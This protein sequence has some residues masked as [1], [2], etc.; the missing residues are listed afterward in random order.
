M[1]EFFQ[2]L[3]DTTGY[4][5][6]W[7]CG[8]WSPFEGWLHIVSDL[9]IFAAYFA[10]PLSIF[11]YAIGRRQ[12]LTFPKLYWLFAAFIFSCGLTHLL[13]AAIFW[14]PWYRLSGLVK[15]ITAVI[16]ITTA[17]VLIRALPTALRLPGVARLNAELE[18]EV[19][20]RARSE[21][22][23]RTFST[24]LNLAMQHAGLGDWS[25]NAATDAVTFSPAGYAMFGLPPDEPITWTGIRALIHPDDRDH[26][27]AAVQRAITDRSEY[28]MEYR[29]RRPADGVEVWISARGRAEYD[30]DGRA[31]EMLGIVQDV[32]ARRRAE[33]ERE[34]LLTKESAARAAAERASRIK[35]DFLA[36]LS[37]ELRT[38][39]NAVLGWTQIL[40]LR[41][42]N[43]PELVDGLRVIERNTRVQARL[44]EDLLDINRVISGKIRLDVREV[45][46][47]AVVTAAA[48]DVE[49]A[50][51]ARHLRLHRV[52]PGVATPVHGDPARL[53]QIVWNL[54]T[55][56]IKFSPPESV[57]D[58]RLESTPVH[59]TVVVHDRGSGIEPD[60]LPFIF[61]RFSQAELPP[62][63]R[64]AGLGLGLAI[65]R[66]LTRMHGGRVE[67]E[68]AGQN[69]GATFR[70]S[71]P[72]AGQ[73]GSL[74]LPGSADPTPAELPAPSPTAFE[75]IRIL[76]V[77]DAADSLEMLDRL[78]AGEGARVTAVDSAAAAIRQLASAR[79]D[80][81][82]SDLNMPLMTGY[83]LIRAIR[84][85]ATPHPEVPAIAVSALA[86]P[87]DRQRAR[88]AGFQAFVAKPLDLAEFRAAAARVLAGKV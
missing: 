9:G 62:H 76:L 79:Y 28:T 34:E 52:L 60:F 54:L 21:A 12:D 27:E 42:G 13:D 19:Q 66:H 1:L 15:F 72:L 56:A 83:E 82:V 37:H 61:D 17:V 70:F 33:R 69:L 31:L 85:G 43:D 26:A 87:E 59:A 36:T 18:R 14:H 81:L 65:V 32:T 75:G 77:D 25:W 16:S 84:R 10:I 3:F 30:A 63:H 24:R 35:D 86:R 4:V 51:A 8:L 55:N 48:N 40:A 6:R 20:E 41:A 67:A 74:D 68:S 44:V 80:L 39:L 23:A 45:D 53:Q 64:N 22:A 88:D 57:I 50:A 2:K 73:P 78:L 11:F 58:L 7:T 47:G 49:P 71:L 46:L 29:V 5:A 38:P